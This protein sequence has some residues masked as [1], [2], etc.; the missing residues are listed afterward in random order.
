MTES[1]QKARAGIEELRDKPNVEEIQCEKNA[2]VVND[3]FIVRLEGKFMDFDEGYEG[4]VV[5]I[6]CDRMNTTIKCRNI[7][8]AKRAVNFYDE[9]DQNVAAFYTHVG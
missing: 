7:S 2:W 6:Q 4:L 5:H 3:E 8:I 1:W 9:K